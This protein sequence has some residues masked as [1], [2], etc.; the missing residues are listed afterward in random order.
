MFGNLSGP[1]LL[2]LIGVVLLAIIGLV[3]WLIVWSVKRSQKTAAERQIELQRA[4]EAGIDTA[5]QQ[6]GYR[7]TL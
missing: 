5:Q 1:S 3:T 6:D 4:Y 7:S 2:L